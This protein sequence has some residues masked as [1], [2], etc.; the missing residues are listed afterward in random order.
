MPTALI[1]GAS[2]GIGATFAERLARDGY[3]L[4]LV[5]RDTARLESLAARL[6]ATYGVGAEVLPADL[7]DTGACRQVERRLADPDRPVDLLVNNAGF[8][9]RTPFLA[10]DVEEDVRLLR[11]LVEA[12]LRLTHAALPGMV[13]RGRGDVINVSSV[14][15]FVPWKTY[16]AAKAWVTSFSEGL[17]GQLRGTGVRVLALCPGFTHTEFHDRAGLSPAMA[18]PWLWLRATDVV[19]AALHDLRSGRVVSVP[20]RRYRVL[21]ALA[22]HAPRALVRRVAS[23]R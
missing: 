23:A 6:R 14:A 5:A 20:S 15:G 17:A 18:P 10:T 19:D 4:V 16:G 2:A 21:T 12:V 22:R 8:G 11:V 1:T 7:A 3:D 9:L 13:Q